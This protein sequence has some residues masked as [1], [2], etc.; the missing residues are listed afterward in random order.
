MGREMAIYRLQVD[1]HGLLEFLCAD[2]RERD[3]QAPPISGAGVT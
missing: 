2:V 3:V 1:R